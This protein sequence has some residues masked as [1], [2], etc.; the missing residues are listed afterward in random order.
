LVRFAGSFGSVPLRIAA[1]SAFAGLWPALAGL[2]PV[3]RSAG[4]APVARSAGLAPVAQLFCSVRLLSA[5]E[6][7][8]LCPEDFSLSGT[9][10]CFAVLCLCL[11]GC[12]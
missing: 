7:P 1:C 11:G 9:V 4:L 3:A 2:A 6:Q 8:R 10:R 5:A 12:R